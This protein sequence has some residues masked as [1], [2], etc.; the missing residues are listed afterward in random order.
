MEKVT[1]KGT[2]PF[3]HKIMA[4]HYRG[5]DL[6][7]LTRLFQQVQR[8]FEGKYTGYQ[9]CDTPYH[10]FTHM[11]EATVAVT[12][13]LDGHLKSGRAPRLSARDFELA[14]VAS[15]LHDSGYIKE[16]GDRRG[17][18]AKYTLTHVARSMKLAG[19]FLPS[20]GCSRREIRAVQTAIS[21]TS[22]EFD[23]RRIRFRNAVERF[24]GYALATGDVLGQM[25]A[26]EYPRRLPRLYREF[27]EAT[28]YAK[29][30]CGGI[31]DFRCEKDLFRKTR[32][33]FDC[34]MFPK[35]K[36]QWGGVHRELLHHFG[37]GRNEYLEAV[38]RNLKRIDRMARAPR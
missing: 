9:A 31:A 27:V 34:C 16:R 11:C 19:K 38:E 10:N 28:K 37:S 22:N 35:I 4:A 18:G 15:L 13:L 17:S 12:R 20:F 26:P 36:T 29:I 3:I 32:A 14:I 2:L 8:L 5:H 7:F 23:L 30:S 6:T 1:T 21:C 33:F 25:A 24:L